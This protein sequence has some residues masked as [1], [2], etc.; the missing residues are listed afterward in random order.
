MV[1]RSGVH[2]SWPESCRMSNTT[3][4]QGEENLVLEEM[5]FIGHFNFIDATYGL[6]IGEGTQITNYVSILTHSSHNAVRLYGRDYIKVA[7]KKAY[8]QG[9]VRIGKYAYIGPHS[10][11]MPKTNIGKGSLVGAYSYVKGDYPDFAIITGNPGRVVGDTRKMDERLLI[12]YP[13]LKT[14]YDAWAKN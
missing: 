10:V 6:E 5:V 11:I 13:E 4:L 2:K 9:A 8:N 1:G 12:Q 7:Q 14:S 3:A